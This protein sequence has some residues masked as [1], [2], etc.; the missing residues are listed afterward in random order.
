MEHNSTTPPW[1][2]VPVRDVHGP[3]RRKW[4]LTQRS[5]LFSEMSASR[6]VACFML[7][8]EMPTRDDYPRTVAEVLDGQ[9]RFR[10]ATIQAVLR[11]KAKRPWSGLPIERMLKLRLLHRNLCRIYGR[12]TSLLSRRLDGSFSGSSSYCPSCDVIT[13]RGKLSVVTYLHEFAHALGKG[14]RGACRWSIHLFR[15]CFPEQFARCRSEGHVL[16]RR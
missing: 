7:P 13:L 5:L 1:E 11:F 9:I 15:R 4:P 8:G 2:A 3:S 10:Q 14:E 6:Q 12:E 16:R